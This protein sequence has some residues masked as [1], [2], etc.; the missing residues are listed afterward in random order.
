MSVQQIYLLTIDV[1]D[2]DLEDVVTLRFCTGHGFTTRPDNTPA[3][4]F[5]DPRIITAPSLAQKV[6][7]AWRGDA[8]PTYGAGEIVLNNADGELDWLIDA[9]LDG[10]AFVLKLGPILGDHDADFETVMTGTMQQPEFTMS[11]VIIRARDRLAQLDV[12]LQVIKYAGTNSGSSGVEGLPDDITGRPKPL[13]YG[14]CLNVMAVP[15]NTTAL[16]YQLHNGQIEAIDA[17]YDKGVVLTGAGDVADLAALQA[18]SIS[19]GQ[20][21]TCLTLGLFRLGSSPSGRITADVRGDKQGGVYAYTAGQIARRLVVDHTDIDSVDVPASVITALDTA[22]DAVVGYFTADETTVLTALSAVLGS[23]G[24]WFAFDP[25]GQFSAAV[26]VSPAGAPVAEL[27]DEQIINPQ[28]QATDDE[29]GGLPAYRIL[30]EYGRC[31]TPQS[32][33]ELAA[34]VSD[35]R[36]AFASADYRVADAVD[37]NVLIVHPLAPELKHQSLLLDAADAQT[38]ADRR[39]ALYAQRRDYWLQ[40]VPLEAVPAGLPLGA[41]VEMQ[42][43]RF[44]YDSGRLMIV[45]GIENSPLQG[46]IDLTVWG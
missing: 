34:G 3:N 1:Y 32:A 44:G 9:G 45:L 46:V 40:R 23:I 26:L 14:E 28:R 31:W 37:E 16:I 39:L 6:I 42:L 43:D 35:A 19:A 4:T 7:A 2:T 33:D 38:E 21:K 24:A 11:R 12:P 29:G 13:C 15:V 17:V 10:R 22:N 25:V 20:Y 8:Q 5:Y 27:T 41:V 36:R 30:L 18:A